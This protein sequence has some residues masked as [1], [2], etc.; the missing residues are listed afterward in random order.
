MLIIATIGLDI[1]KA[2]FSAH[3]AAA[4]GKEVKTAEMK[5]GAFRAGPMR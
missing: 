3:C 4:S 1:A 5:R 2:S